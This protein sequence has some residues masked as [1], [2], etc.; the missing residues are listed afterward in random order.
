MSFFDSYDGEL[1]VP[2]NPTYSV[3][4]TTKLA[5]EPAVLEKLW[6]ELLTTYDLRRMKGYFVDSS[7]T[8]WHVEATEFQI[9]INT[10]RAD[11]PAKIIFIGKRANEIT[12]E[13]LQAQLVMFG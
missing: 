8:R 1:V 7:G 5:V 10:A 9:Q 12:R 2:D 4:D 11:E 6:Q 13:L 3:I